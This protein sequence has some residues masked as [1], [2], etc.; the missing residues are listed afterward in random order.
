MILRIWRTGVDPGRWREYAEF[1][2]EHS[3]PMFRAQPGCRGVLFV[4]LPQG[5]GA[6][7]CSFW[8]DQESI[9]ALKSSATYQ[10]T[11]ARLLATGLLTG[12]Q[13]VEILEVAGGAIDILKELDE[14]GG[15]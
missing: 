6:A 11:V 13:T 4:R 15:R 8:D 2:R 1:E 7:A 3:L 12:D 5:V 9:E 14:F 10:A